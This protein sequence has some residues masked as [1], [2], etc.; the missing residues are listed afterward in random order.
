MAKRIDTVE[1]A[2]IVRAMLKR[3]FPEV[4]FSVRS[5]RYSGGSS[6]D[7]N[8][9]DGPMTSEVKQVVSYF[10]GAEFD[11]MIDLKSYKGDKEWRGETVRFGVDFI[12]PHRDYSRGM[13]E[14]AVAKVA[15]DFGIETPEVRDG[16]SGAYIHDPVGAFVGNSSQRIGDLVYRLLESG[17]Y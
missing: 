7:V 3:T 15:K 11:G 16:Y 12:Q 10:D 2:K 13:L 1:V 17:R 14:D 6:I 8:W 9:T 4:K 5:S